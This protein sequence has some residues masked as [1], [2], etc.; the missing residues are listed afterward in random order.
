MFSRH[1]SSLICRKI[2]HVL[3]AVILFH[4]VLTVGSQIAVRLSALLTGRTL[5]HRNIITLIFLVLISVSG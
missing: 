2:P 1:I 5:L 3:R 4:I